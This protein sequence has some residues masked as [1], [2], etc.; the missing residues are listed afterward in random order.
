MIPEAPKVVQRS[1]TAN[2]GAFQM[3]PQ[4][5]TRHYSDWNSAEALPRRAPMHLRASTAADATP[6]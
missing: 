1:R 6:D 5:L 2:L 3:C 4:R